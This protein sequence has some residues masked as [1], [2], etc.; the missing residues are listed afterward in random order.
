MLFTWVWCNF[1]FIGSF[2]DF[3]N[4]FVFGIF[5]I[6]NIFG[7]FLLI[8]WNCFVDRVSKIR[9]IFG[10]LLCL[11][12]N[13]WLIESPEETIWFEKCSVVDEFLVSILR[14][15]GK[16]S[17]Y[18]VEMSIELNQ[19]LFQFVKNIGQILVILFEFV[20]WEV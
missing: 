9:K 19:A 11:S 13:F 20:S 8:F 6:L 2:F 12:E 4:S 14:F 3:W 1:N 16:L 18:F 17:H 15:H 10:D 7:N 5:W